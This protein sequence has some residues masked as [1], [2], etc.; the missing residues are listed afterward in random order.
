MGSAPGQGGVHMLASA[1]RRLAAFGVGLT[2][3]GSVVWVAPAASA[4]PVA[5]PP[6]VPRINW[7]P[8]FHQISAFTE[9]AYQCALANVPLDYDSPNGTSVG[10][11]LVRIP[12]R[13]PAHKIGTI[14]L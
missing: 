5:K 9:T 12:A 10:L 14:F 13:D 4:A 2:L 8:C 1:V 3:A 11:S 7:S 6:A